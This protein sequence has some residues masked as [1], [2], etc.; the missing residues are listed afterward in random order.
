MTIEQNKHLR[1]RE[2]S[3]RFFADEAQI[4][5]IKTEEELIRSQC[6]LSYAVL[7]KCPIPKE[8]IIRLKKRAMR[9]CYE[10]RVLIFFE[11]V[12]E[13]QD[14]LYFVDFMKRNERL[15]DEIIE[16]KVA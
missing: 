14:M 10:K 12:S 8:A 16:K 5:R 1:I 6:L 2:V 15:L 7:C 3:M 13:N 9:I 11:K 4:E